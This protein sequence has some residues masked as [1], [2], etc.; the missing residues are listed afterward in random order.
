MARRKRCVV[1]RRRTLEGKR[2]KRAE[3][4]ETIRDQIAKNENKIKKKSVRIFFLCAVVNCWIY[5][6]YARVKHTISTFAFRQDVFDEQIMWLSWAKNPP[7]PLFVQYFQNPLAD[8]RIYKKSE[9]SSDSATNCQYFKQNSYK[10]MF[11]RIERRFNQYSE[12][13]Y[14]LFTAITYLCGIDAKHFLNDPPSNKNAIM[15]SVLIPEGKVI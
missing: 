4:E 13:L 11:K 15:S 14:L 7:N 12:S 2:R 5:Q 6:K 3:K 9:K 1:K 8:L 10:T